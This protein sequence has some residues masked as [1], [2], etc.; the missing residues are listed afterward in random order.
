MSNID[1]RIVQMQFDNKQFE[2]GV[3]ETLDSLAALRK[4]LNL[5][6]ATRGLEDLDKG[7]G[8]INLNP[9]KDGIGTIA[10]RFTTMGMVGMTIL[11]DLTRSAFQLGKQLAFTLTVQPITSGFS[12]YETQI[13]AIQT[14]LANT[15]KQGTTLTD[16][17][18]ALRELNTYADK[19]IYNFT[20]MTR[21]IGTFTAAGVE[22][23]TSVE[24]IKG[25]ANLAAV[26]GSNPQQAATAMYQ[27]SQALSSGTVKLMDWNSVVNAGMGGALFKDA[28]METARV[29]GV[30][31]DDYLEEAGS[32]RETLQKGWLS[33]DILLETLAKFTGDLTN[34]Q[35]EAMGYTKEQIDGI[36]ELGKMANDAATKVKTLTQLRETLMEAAQS[37]W[38]MSWE[39]IIGD[40]NEA[41]SLLTIIADTLGAVI[42]RSA[43]TRNAILQGW[44]DLGG[45]ERLINGVTEGLTNLVAI[46]KPIGEAFRELFPPMTGEKLYGL[47]V[48]LGK[49]G[50]Q[51]KMGEDSLET[52]KGVFRGF[53]S[54]LDIGRLILV[55]V[56]KTLHEILAEPLKVIGKDIINFI[57]RFAERGVELRQSILDQGGAISYFGNRIAELRDHI[58]PAL[59]F[60]NK[61]RLYLGAALGY[62]QQQVDKIDFSSLSNA[63]KVFKFRFNLQPLT[64]IWLIFLKSLGALWL[65]IKSIVPTIVKSISFLSNGMD[66]LF[67]TLSNATNNFDP[68]NFMSTLQGGFFAGL[69]LAIGRFF[70]AGGDIL[71][72]FG[73]VMEGLGDALEAFT[74]N[75]QS[76]TLLNIAAAVGILAVSIV[77]IGSVDPNRV[78]SSLAAITVMMVELTVAMAALGKMPGLGFSGAAMNLVVIATAL[79]IISGAVKRL[80]SI[81][82]E[83]LIRGLFGL[84]AI[85]LMLKGIL[86]AFS[87]SSGMMISSAVALGIIALAINSLSLSVR[88]LGKMDPDDLMQGL[89]GL[90]VILTGLS[91]FTRVMAGSKGFILA[92]IGIQILSTALLGLIGSIFL[93]GRMNLDTLK[94]GLLGMAGALVI[95]AATMHAM[96]KNMPVSALSLVVVAGALVVLAKALSMIG[97]LSW[98]DMIKSL[99][100][101]AISLGLITLALYAM[102]STI[103]GSIALAIASGALVLLAVA[104]QQLGKMSLKEIGLALLAIAGTMLVL[105]VSASLMTPL[106]PALFALAAAMALIGAAS[107]LFGVGILAL[108]VGL[109]ALGAGGAAGITALVLALG[110]VINLIPFVAVALGKALISIVTTLADGSKVLVQ[111]LVTLIGA[112]IDGLVELTPKFVD[113]LLTLITTLLTTLSAKLPTILAA[114]YEILKS[115][116][117]G[118]VDNIGEITVLVADIIINFL[119]AMGK[120]LPEIVDAGFKFMISFL[121]GL[122]VSIET[123]I[124]TLMASAAKVGKAII[125]GILGGLGTSV[126]ELISGLVDLGSTIISTLENVLGIDS[127]SD[128]TYDQAGDLI[129]GYVNGLAHYAQEAYDEAANVATGIIDGLSTV[130][131]SISNALDENIDFEP[132]ITPIVDLDEVLTNATTIDKV[133]SDSGGLISGAFGQ[134]KSISRNMNEQNSPNNVDVSGDSDDPSGRTIQFIQHN[135]SPKSLNR[136]EIYRQTQNLLLEARGSE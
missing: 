108:S 125:D 72:G 65:G 106:L 110:A 64:T 135:H 129:G 115:L 11:Q 133:L 114:G 22:L 104:L 29:Q 19:T 83:G 9:L 94:Q 87:K 90:G 31:I 62:L 123:N 99:A 75:I 23:D 12:E 85:L 26:S 132:V 5:K 57:I 63:L 89:I 52:L 47:T 130:G 91:A 112:L 82:P 71:S 128:E 46:T 2:R 42:G 58:K 24:A 50:K 100:G 80:A 21:N 38:T 44:Q 95:I 131:A 79:L 81:D 13:N 56:G 20:E 118:V 74:T 119:D 35:L 51:I 93:L 78:R 6:G 33:K 117:R 88:M 68:N 111:G 136:F 96:P 18:D 102:S 109:A 92:A 67:E 10:R 41:K 76:K 121:D 70:M 55:D 113:A 27:L 43:D 25:I 32:F 14:I 124:P 16:V 40:F 134:A 28:L 59:D 84:G 66:K 116:L 127:P 4:E 122:A 61:I 15:S 1:Q 3:S 107:M 7:I 98:E 8:R 53:F 17:S 120:K 30:A 36:T 39:L 48:L 101:L 54:F 34:D 97:A 126:T 73:D 86:P 103:P 69:L 60:A 49:F 105:G 77:L 45:R 37:G